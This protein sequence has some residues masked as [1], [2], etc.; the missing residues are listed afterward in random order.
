[1]PLLDVDKLLQ[2]ITE[3]EPAGPNLEYDAAFTALE[4]AAAGKPEQQMG[5]TIVPAEPPDWNAV[6][7][8]SLTLLART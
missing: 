7:E 8:Q 5:G 2:P 1:M 6:F 3:A 4:K